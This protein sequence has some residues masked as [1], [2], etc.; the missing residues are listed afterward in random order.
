MSAFGIQTELT[1]I[2]GMRHP[3]M[4]AGMGP[5]SGAELAAAVSNAGGLGVIGGVGYTPRILRL[6]IKHLKD[7]LVDPRLP[8]GVDLLLPKSQSFMG[9]SIG[10]D[11][12]TQHLNELCDVMIDTECK[13]LVVAIG[14]PPRFMV[15]KLHRPSTARSQGGGSRSGHRVCSGRR[16]RRAHQHCPDLVVAA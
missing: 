2:L 12:W 14:V 3:I 9:K 11:S 4:L 8:F 10:K 5:I 13:L 16:G 15:D 1:K 7:K 6:Q